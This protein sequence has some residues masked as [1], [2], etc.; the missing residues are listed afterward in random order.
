[1]RRIP[2]LRA[3]GQRSA[4]FARGARAVAGRMRVVVGAVAVVCA[5]GVDR[6]GVGQCVGKR[7]ALLVVRWS[8]ACGAGVRRVGV[9]FRRRR[10]GFWYS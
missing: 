6:A 3:G 4:M 1:M 8:S 5:C 9:A 2:V 10:S 7:R